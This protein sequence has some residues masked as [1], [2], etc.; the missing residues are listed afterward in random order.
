M[1]M[2]RQWAMPTHETFSCP[3]IKS[4]VERWLKE[5]PIT[6]DPFARDSKYGTFTND[7]NPE[8]SAQYHLTAIDFLKKMRSYGLKAD[9]IIFDP[10]Y[11]L[12]QIKTM[13]DGWGA[14]MSMREAQ[15]AGHW[16]DE[17]SIIMDILKP[18][19]I[20]LHFGWHT[21]GLGK[22]RGAVIEEILLVAHGRAHNDTI[23]M[24]ERRL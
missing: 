3:P 21:Q 22:K 15:N 17:K 9:A 10:P 18:N 24:A 13:Y 5:A 1:K 7:L 11:S 6:V 4:F 19:G 20:F 8:T 23:C 16:G 2:S 12:T 14:K